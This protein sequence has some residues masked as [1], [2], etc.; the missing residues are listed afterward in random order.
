MLEF[1][2]E[3]FFSPEFDNYPIFSD[4]GYF[5][6][7]SILFLIVIVVIIFYYTILGNQPWGEP[8][9]RPLFWIIFLVSTSLLVFFFTVYW[10]GFKVFE[11]VDG[12]RAIPN[13]IWVFGFIN[14]LFAVIL[15]FV[16]SIIAKRFSKHTLKIPF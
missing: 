3:L 1:F 14:A 16:F 15:F 10:V 5:T 6:G 12:W 11:I 7:A 2:Y 9:S 13:D 4:S 8:Y